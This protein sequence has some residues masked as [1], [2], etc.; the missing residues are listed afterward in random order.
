MCINS[1]NNFIGKSDNLKP[2]GTL[3]TIEI[4]PKTIQ[5][6][7]QNDSIKKDKQKQGFLEK[8]QIA[9]T[10]VRGYGTSRN[11]LK[12]KP[13]NKYLTK[14]LSLNSSPK[15]VSLINIY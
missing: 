13:D 15:K 5:I 1:P 4:L 14:N 2:T 9:D 7:I 8:T 11:N 10:S 12:I 6:N 3:A